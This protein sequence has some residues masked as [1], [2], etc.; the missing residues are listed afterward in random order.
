MQPV[1]LGPVL[2]EIISPRV[3]PRLYPHCASQHPLAIRISVRQARGRLLVRVAVERVELRHVI[4]DDTIVDPGDVAHVVASIE[5]SKLARL[6]D[7]T[8][9]ER[10]VDLV[11][12]RSIENQHQAVRTKSSAPSAWAYLRLDDVQLGS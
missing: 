10:V 5:R 12:N 3:S 7:L 11:A 9:T 8:S 1:P 6:R 4:V 2:D